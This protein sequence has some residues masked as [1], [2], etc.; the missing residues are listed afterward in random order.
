MAPGV[1]LLGAAI[2]TWVLEHRRRKSW[3]R[4]RGTV[5]DSGRQSIRRGRTYYCPAVQ[6][7]GPLGE[8][9]EFRSRVGTRFEYY[10]AGAPV[11]VLFNPK[12]PQEA[13]IDQ[14]SM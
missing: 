2:G 5:C 7:T 3:L 10:K 12:A 13:V 6:F 1:L 9:V 4:T 8:T 14:F 11:L